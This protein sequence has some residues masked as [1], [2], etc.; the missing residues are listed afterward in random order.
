M[1]EPI[2]VK[3]LWRMLGK[4]PGDCIL[5][6]HCSGVDHSG[7]TISFTS[8]SFDRVIY[9]LDGDVL[10]LIF[11]VLFEHSFTTGICRHE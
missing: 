2:T 10:N 7:N 11:P 1:S 9:S 3:D 6:I 8:L 5:N 4:L